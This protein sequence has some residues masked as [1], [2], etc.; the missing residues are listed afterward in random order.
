M[1]SQLPMGAGLGS[2]AAFAV[3]FAGAV[4]SASGKLT[5]PIKPNNTQQIPEV[6]KAKFKLPTANCVPLSHSSFSDWS[7]DDL[8]LINKWS[9]TV[10]Q[11]IHGTP[12]GIDNSISCHGEC[13]SMASLYNAQFG[14]TIQRKI[15]MGE[16][17]TDCFIQKLDTDNIYEWSLR[18]PVFAIQLENIE[19]EI[20]TDCQ[21]KCQIHQYFPPSKF[22]SIQQLSITFYYACFNALQYVA[23][24]G[25]REFY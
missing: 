12:S 11:I 3:A 22:P 8:D 21:L 16:I 14:C 4:L 20:L 17:L 9:F 6:L 19:R 10:E 13:S 24:C 15:L 2:S 18:Q 1:T 5:S 23:L 25:I 7:R